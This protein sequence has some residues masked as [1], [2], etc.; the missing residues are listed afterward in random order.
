[1]AR[2]LALDRRRL[3]AEHERVTGSLSVKTPNSHSA[4]AMIE[5]G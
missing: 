3:A 1:M 4:R 2:E 5:H